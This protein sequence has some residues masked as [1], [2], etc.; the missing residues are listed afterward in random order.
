MAF[1][2]QQSR[3]Y[4]KKY[5]CAHKEKALA[6][7]SAYDKK[8]RKTGVPKGAHPWLG[9]PKVCFNMADLVQAPT[10]KFEQRLNLILSGR[11][12]FTN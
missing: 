12:G 5:Y 7:Q 11:M 6:Y 9:A 3:D 1:T 8:H 10:A 4:Q 2:K